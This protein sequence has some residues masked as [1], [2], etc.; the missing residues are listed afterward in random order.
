[1]IRK[2]T[3]LR[4]KAKIAL[5]KC[6]PRYRNQARERLQRLE[7]ALYMAKQERDSI[8]QRSNRDLVCDH[9]SSGVAA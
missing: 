1:M 3:I 7:F 6:E 5:A 8:R 4:D 9:R 2:L